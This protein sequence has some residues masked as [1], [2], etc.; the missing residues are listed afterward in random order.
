MLVRRLP[1]IYQGHMLVVR[2]AG[3]GGQGPCQGF[4]ILFHQ[5]EE[6][7]PVLRDI[8]IASKG[9]NDQVNGQVICMDPGML[10]MR[11]CP[12]VGEALGNVCR[13]GSTKIQK[14]IGNCRVLCVCGKTYFKHR[15]RQ[16]ISRCPCTPKRGRTHHVVANGHH[17]IS[18]VKVP[19]YLCKT[20]NDSTSSGVSATIKRATKKHRELVERVDHITVVWRVLHVR[21]QC[22]MTY[23]LLTCILNRE[24]GRHNVCRRG[25]TSVRHK[26]A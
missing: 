10:C 20:C 15:A 22:Q 2:F 4:A 12:A 25:L 7:L 24:Q 1:Q 3:F 18:T 21:E 14:Q 26:C 5:M 23:N 16:K 6:E 8:V 17:V 11:S 19:L 13:C 9:V